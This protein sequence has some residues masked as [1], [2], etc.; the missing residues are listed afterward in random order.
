MNLFLSLVKSLDKISVHSPFFVIFAP[1]LVFLPPP[2]PPLIAFRTYTP[3]NFTI[4]HCT[5]NLM[6]TNTFSM[7]VSKTYCLFHFQTEICPFSYFFI[8]SIFGPRKNAIYLRIF[9]R[10]F[11]MELKYPENKEIINGIYYRFS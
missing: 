8:R 3:S 7:A 11:P 10:T 5:D 1:F 2:P 4:F 9:L 6:K